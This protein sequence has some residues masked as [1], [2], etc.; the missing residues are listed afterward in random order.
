LSKCFQLVYFD[1]TCEHAR[2]IALLGSKHS[3]SINVS[4]SVSVNGTSLCVDI[5]FF[6][7]YVYEDQS[8]C[9]STMWTISSDTA[10]DT[11]RFQCS[12]VQS[13]AM[14]YRVEWR[15]V[16]GTLSK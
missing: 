13:S 2:A 11:S 6:L 7:W 4:V 16:P 15:G 8:Q 12:T 1:I 3:D 14:Q 9:Y 5:S 10:D